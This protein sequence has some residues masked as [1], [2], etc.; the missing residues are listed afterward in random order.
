MNKLSLILSVIFLLITFFS[1]KAKGKV[2]YNKNET[3]IQKNT[4]GKS[5][6]LLNR[7]EVIKKMDKT[8][9]NKQELNSLLSEVRIINTHL[10]AV[11]GGIY[12]SAGALIVILI[13]LLFLI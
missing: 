13:V 3:S 1:V 2:D 7:L 8:Q 5:S 10:V 6:E 4:Q 12:I 11:D 9:M